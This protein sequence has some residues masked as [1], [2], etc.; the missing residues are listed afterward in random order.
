MQI[1]MDHSRNVQVDLLGVT[2]GDDCN[3]QIRGHMNA[4]KTRI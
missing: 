4:Q 2:L 1:N 3:G